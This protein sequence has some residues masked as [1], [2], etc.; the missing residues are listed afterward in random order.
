MLPKTLTL[1]LLAG[2]AAAIA[3]PAPEGVSLNPAGFIA[4]SKPAPV[5]KRQDDGQCGFMQIEC[6]IGCIPSTWTCCPSGAGGCGILEKCQLGSNGEYGCCPI[7]KTCIG[8]GGV[9]TDD[10]LGG[11]TPQTTRGSGGG[12]LP[13]PTPTDDDFG[14]PTATGGLT[15]PGGDDSSDDSLDTPTTALPTATSGS[16]GGGNPSSGNGNT[17]NG[18]DEGSSAAR[19]AVSFMGAIAALLAL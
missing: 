11:S 10:S 3:A 2:S 12:S 6:G 19:N 9:T 16:F 5:V 8:E 1:A 14:T 15:F 4:A 18:G 17:R 7:G 13:D